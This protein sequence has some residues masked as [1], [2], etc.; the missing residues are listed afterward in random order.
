MIDSNYM[1]TKPKPEYLP[2]E[3]ETLVI[4][5]HDAQ[6]HVAR[7]YR[8]CDCPQCSPVGEDCPAAETS[9]LE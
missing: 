6:E 3:R 4:N 1:N 8:R 7:K 5:P 2:D 9:E